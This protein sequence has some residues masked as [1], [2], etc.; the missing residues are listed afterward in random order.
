MQSC[1]VIA[2][3]QRGSD[4]IDAVKAYGWVCTNADEAGHLLDKPLDRD[5]L[6]WWGKQIG[7]DGGLALQRIS[8]LATA[9]RRR[10][11]QWLIGRTTS[12]RA[13]RASADVALNE[14]T[15]DTELE[16]S[17]DGRLIHVHRYRPRDH[18]GVIGMMLAFLL[19]P[20]LPY[21]ATVRRCALRSCDQYFL[22]TP[23]AKGGPRRRYCRPEHQQE[24]DGARATERVRQYRVALRK[25]K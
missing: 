9:L 23:G 19:D 6:E 22:A 24:A 20:A 12:L 1:L 7:D 14:V 4:P 13:L 18:E 11:D 17:A 5:S 16:L 15:V 10:L 3:V 8:S 21:G 2:N 25:H